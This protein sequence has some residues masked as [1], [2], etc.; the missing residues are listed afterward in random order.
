MDADGR[1]TGWTQCLASATK[2]Y[3]RPNLKPE[4]RWMP[5][6]YEARRFPVFLIWESDLWSTIAHAFEDVARQVPPAG[7]PL[8]SLS[9]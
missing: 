8:E 1:V 2:H 6:L 9:R 7:G 4:E 3:R 5:E